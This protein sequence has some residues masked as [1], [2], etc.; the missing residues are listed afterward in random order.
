MT[1]AYTLCSMECKLWQHNGGLQVVG[2]EPSQPA[3][4]LETCHNDGHQNALLAFLFIAF[5]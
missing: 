3:A 5:Y 1:H 2:S 4:L